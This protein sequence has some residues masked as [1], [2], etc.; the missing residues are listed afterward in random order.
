MGSRADNID[1]LRGE[2][3]GKLNVDLDSFT[4]RRLAPGAF[5]SVPIDHVRSEKLGKVFITPETKAML[6]LIGEPHDIGPSGVAALLVEELRHQGQLAQVWRAQRNRRRKA[7][8]RRKYGPP[9]RS[10][11]GQSEVPK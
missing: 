6:A 5:A 11:D 8:Y 3:S 10:N 7:L 2:A 1:N 9:K 4:K